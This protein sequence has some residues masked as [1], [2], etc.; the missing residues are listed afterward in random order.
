[1][2]HPQQ[3]QVCLVSPPRFD[4]PAFADTLAAILDQQAIACFR[5]ALASQDEDEVRRVADRMRETCHARDVAIVISTHYR[6]VGPLGLD[7]CHL[8]DGARHVRDV[9][10]ALGGDAIVGACCANSRHTGMSAGEA[11][12]DYVA[13][14]PITA[15]GLGD[16]ET[17]PFDLFE[18]WSEMIEVPVIAEGGLTPDLVTRLAPVVDFLAFGAEIWT[19]ES[20]PAQLASLLAPVAV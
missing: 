19:A 7:G 6:L 17:A 10:K 13:F 2:P 18:W 5:L 9:R 15:S 11:G 8:E 3:P 14:G 4:L 1:M 20:P 12:A 16:G